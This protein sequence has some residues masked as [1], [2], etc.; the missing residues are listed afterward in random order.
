METRRSRRYQSLRIEP[1][2]EE[3]M[4]DLTRELSEI[5]NYDVSLDDNCI[6][7]FLYN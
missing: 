3:I 1:F 6:T 5:S 4:R 7:R 2:L